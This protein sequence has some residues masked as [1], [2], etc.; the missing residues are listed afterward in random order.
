MELTPA[1]CVLCRGWF[2]STGSEVSLS[3]SNS[4]VDM[5]GLDPAAGGG[6]GGAVERWSV[7]GP[8]P[9]VQHSASDLGSDGSAAGLTF[10]GSSMIRVDNAMDGPSD[11][12]Q[13]RTRA[14]I[15]RTKHDAGSAQRVQVRVTD[16]QQS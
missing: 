16:D 5:G 8:R 7:F 6:A 15:G 13:T 9:L 14:P 1:C 12:K 2:S 10:F 3:S 4:S 11:C